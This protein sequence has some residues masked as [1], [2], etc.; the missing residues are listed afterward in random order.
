ML[1]VVGRPIT[2][3]FQLMI[4]VLE[5]DDPFLASLSFGGAASSRGENGEQRGRRYAGRRCVS[6]TRSNPITNPSWLSV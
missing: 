2:F 4:C 1:D 6:F 5:G 3:S